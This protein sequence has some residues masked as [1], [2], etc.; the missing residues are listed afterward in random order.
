MANRR[1]LEQKLKD[2]PF[3]ILQLYI[4]KNNEK[5]Y[6]THFNLIVIINNIE[7]GD[8][9]WLSYDDHTPLSIETK[10]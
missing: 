6:W 8:D 7:L 5:S 10:I 2:L 9:L 3:S 1:P 4:D